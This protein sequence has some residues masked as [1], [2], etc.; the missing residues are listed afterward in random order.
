MIDF[1]EETLNRIEDTISR[2]KELLD[3]VSI[4]IKDMNNANGP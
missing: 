4:I 2:N 1:H 3:E